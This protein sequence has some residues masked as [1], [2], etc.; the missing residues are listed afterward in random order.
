MNG[1]RS[2]IQ[3]AN[4]LPDSPHC[5]VW[6]SDAENPDASWL[7]QDGL[8][9]CGATSN[10]LDGSCSLTVNLVLYVEIESTLNNYACFPHG[11]ASENQQHKF[12]VDQPQPSSNS[13]TAY[14]D[15]NSYEHNG[16]A[17]Y[18]IAE[19]SEHTG[20]DSC[21]GNWGGIGTFSQ[22]TAWQRWIKS[23]LTW[24]TV[25]SDYLLSPS[26]W[27]ATGGPPNTFSFSR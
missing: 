27:I 16:F 17:Q 18:L 7:I 23:S 2:S 14:I 5:V 22:S 21:S 13:W 4:V 12:T 9:K 8:A 20:T 3:V 25:Q 11:Q 19:S 24:F 15:G 6:R 10:G 1:T 26:C